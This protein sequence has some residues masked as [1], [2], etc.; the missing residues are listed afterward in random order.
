MSDIMARHRGEPLHRENEKAEM[1][2]EYVKCYHK[3]LREYMPEITAIQE[4][5]ANLRREEEK[6]WTDFRDLEQS[7][8]NDE[9]L[10]RD[11]REK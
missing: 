7:M 4:M 8:I 5:L 3:I 10:S 1:I 11:T 6:F 2:L 9:V